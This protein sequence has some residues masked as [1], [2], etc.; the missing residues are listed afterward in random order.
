MSRHELLPGGSRRFAATILIAVLLGACTQSAISPSPLQSGA[1]SATPVATPSIAV[2]SPPPC[3]PDPSTALDEP[4]WA[5]EIFYEVFVRSFQDSDGDGVGDLRGLT[6]RLD[7]LNDG[8]ASTDTD[9]GVTALWLMP[10]AESPSYHGY[11]VVD[12]RAVEADYGTAE[13][14][15]AFMA[16]AHERGIKVIVDLVLNHTS[17]E[18]PWFQDAQAPASPLRDW[19]LWADERPFARPDGARVWHEAGEAFYYGYFWEG[20][21]DLNLENEAVTAELDG[22][23]DFW[24][25]EMGVDGFRL[26]AAKHLIEDGDVVENTPETMAWL[27]GFGERLHARHPEALILG[28]VYDASIVTSSYV[29]EGALDLTFDFGL[30]S[31]TITAL[32]SASAGPLVS[33]LAEVAEAYPRGSLATFLTNHD[34]NRIASQLNGNAASLRLAASL[35]LTGPGVP[36]IYYGEEIG[37]TGT[38]PDERIRTPLRWDA[39]APGAGFTGGTPWQ[40]LSFDPEGTD[41]ATEGADADSLLSA[42]RLL[43]RLRTGSVALRQGE[44]IPVTAEDRHVAAFLRSAVDEAV[45]VVANLGS[46]AVSAPVLDLEAGPLCE[47]STARSLP[48]QPGPA[49]LLVNAGGG[50]SGYVPV[51]ELE[52]REAVVIEIVR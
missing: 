43:T 3:P 35:L 5:D 22:V 45:L 41:I 30:A 46:E 12:Y 10:I 17:R 50:F 4:W 13:D 21:P 42:Y 24:L 29:R 23:A 26:D 19:Y 37:M 15:R 51:P 9:L 1:Q 25:Q 32:N 40:A 7:Y 31:S 20:M 16:A 44:L 2:G 34:Q 38:K 14:F 49:P 47:R 28:E 52:A 48:G 6:S 8:D 11:D 27:Q 39:S 18:H 36:F 33:S